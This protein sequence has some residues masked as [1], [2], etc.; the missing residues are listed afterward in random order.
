[1]A[2]NVKATLSSL[3]SKAKASGKFTGGVMIG[4]PK[5]PVDSYTIAFWMQSATVAQVT[6]GTTIEL[7]VVLARI[8]VL[9]LNDKSEDTELETARMASTYTEDI[10]GDFDLAATI[11]KVDAAGEY[12]TPMGVEWGHVDVGGTLYRVSDITI[13]LV[14]D[15]SATTTQ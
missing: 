6:L 14:V 4:E 7:H 12:G 9:T 15:D 5:K 2:F 8:H 1:M 3:T 11:R 13:P 10:L